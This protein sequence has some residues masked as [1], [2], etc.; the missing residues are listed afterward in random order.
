MKT[1]FDPWQNPT[2]PQDVGIS[3][4]EVARRARA[5]SMAR[6]QSPGPL[7]CQI[8][9]TWSLDDPFHADPFRTC[10]DFRHLNVIGDDQPW[11]YWQLADGALIGPKIPIPPLP[12]GLLDWQVRAYAGKVP[13]GT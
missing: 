8:D 7:T 9:G 5:A 1:Y 2:Y 13:A 12:I 4:D 6:A 11:T 10:M 3:E